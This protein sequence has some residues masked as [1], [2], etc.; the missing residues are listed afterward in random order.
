MGQLRFLSKTR[1]ERT[2][3]RKK[4]RVFA[5]QGPPASQ[6]GPRW[7]LPTLAS[8]P[9]DTGSS[10]QTAPGVSLRTFPLGKSE[11]PWP[12][13]QT[14]GGLLLG[15]ATRNQA[16]KWLGHKVRAGDAEDEREEL[17]RHLGGNL[18]LETG[19]RLP[20]QI[21]THRCGGVEGMGWWR[22]SYTAPCCWP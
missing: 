15:T 2:Q 18:S 9:G 17:V 19:K 7:S 21:L 13:L 6:R 10:P 5:S 3:T 12:I 14:R 20:E 11:Q 4:R 22:G 1:K 8:A 16:R